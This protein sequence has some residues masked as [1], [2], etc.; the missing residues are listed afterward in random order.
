MLGLRRRSCRSPSQGADRDLGALGEG[1]GGAAS[2]LPSAIPS[3]GPERGHWQRGSKGKSGAGKGESGAGGLGCVRHLCHH[4]STCPGGVLALAKGSPTPASAQ[5]WVGRAVGAGSNAVIS[6]S[7]YQNSSHLETH[8]HGRHHRGR[9]T[10]PSLVYTPGSA[11]GEG[12]MVARQAIL[13][14]W[15]LAGPGEEPLTTQGPSQSLAAHKNPGSSGAA[16]ERCRGEGTGRIQQQQPL[17]VNPRRQPRLPPAHCS[18]LGCFGLG[19]SCGRH[20]CLPAAST[21]RTFV[22]A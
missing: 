2:S 18:Q 9:E 10:S 12:F 3:P 5:N 14:A 4:P 8:S 21:Q 19:S 13:G 11:Q 1:A 22:S 20:E 15:D 6:P 17:R 7:I 16:A